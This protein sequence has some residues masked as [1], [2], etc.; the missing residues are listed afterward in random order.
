MLT[1][2]RHCTSAPPS[3]RQAAVPKLLR[4]I[5]SAHNHAITDT[6]LTKKQNGHRISRFYQKIHNS[7]QLQSKQRKCQDI[8]LTDWNKYRRNS[9]NKYRALRNS[10][11]NHDQ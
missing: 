7:T 10:D 8:Q 2:T 5:T 11:N 6:S 1:G 3:E 9:G 4:S